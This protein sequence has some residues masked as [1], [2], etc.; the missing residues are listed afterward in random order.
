MV[1]MK[2]RRIDILGFKSFR[3]RARIELSDGMTAI[4][5]PNGCGKSN[6]V[7]AIKWA[8]GDMSPKSL[9]GDSMRDVIFAGSQDYKPMGFAEVTLT[10]ENDGDFEYADAEW[11]DIPREF[12]EVAEISV[13]RRLHR[14]GDSEYLINKVPCRLMDIQDLLAG[15]GVGK[16]GYSIIEQNRV[17][18]IVSA[19][20][21]ERRLLIEEASGITRY[22]TQRDRAERKLTKAE[23]NLTRV[24]DILGEIT[25]QI[26]SLERQ[27]KKA[28]R[29]REY[30]TELE[31][32]EVKVL[33]D[34]RD[35]WDSRRASGS[36][37]LDDLEKALEDARKSV[38]VFEDDL[39]SAKVAA[40]AAEKKHAEITEA[41]YRLDTRLNLAKNRREH[42]TASIEEAKKRQARAEQDV[43]TQLN[44]K[45]LLED[46]L[47]KVAEELD[48][49][50][51]TDGEAAKLA[52]DEERLRRLRDELRDA[53]SAR[54][55]AREAFDDARSQLRWS[56][57]RLAL[58]KEQRTSLD[59][60]EQDLRD[61]IE[62]ASEQVGDLAD[63]TDELEQEKGALVDREA[64]LSRELVERR[65]RA[66]EAHE[67]AEAIERE[68]R[69]VS[70]RRIDL[71]NRVESLEAMRSAGAGYSEI[72]PDIVAWARQTGSSGV[73]GPLGD[74]IDVAE[75]RESDV[76]L[77]LS[78]RVGDILVA[79]RETAFAAYDAVGDGRPVT[80]RVVEDPN[81]AVSAWVESIRAVDGVPDDVA[82]GDIVVTPSLVVFGDG[83]VVGG[84]SS[85]QA[86]TLLRQ[87]RLL[88]EYRAELEDA[89]A[90]ERELDESLQAAMQAARD[91][92]ERVDENRRALD[93]VRLDLRAKER[94]IASEAREIERAKGSVARL[95]AQ[96]VPI[97]GKQEQLDREANELD[98]KRAELESK[99]AGFE[100]AAAAA[101][102]GLAELRETTEIL[103]ERVTSEKVR[104]AQARERRRNLV[105]SRERLTRSISSTTKLIANYGQE[106]EE[107]AIRTEELQQEVERHAD[108]VSNANAEREEAR[109]GVEAS[110]VE[111][112]AANQSVEEI[113]L[114]MRKRRERVEALIE[115]KQK[116]ELGANEAKMRVAGI[117]EQ[118]SERFGLHPGAAAKIARGVE[119]EADAAMARRDELRDKVDKLGPVNP[120]AEEEYDEAVE[121][122]RFLLEQQADLQSS[123]ADLK[124]AIA[125]MDRE[126]R[127]RFKETFDAVNAKFMEVFPRL[128][129]G[130]RAELILTE[131]DDLLSTGVDIQ[132]QPPGKRLQSVSLLSGGEKALTATSLIFSIFLLK[133]TPFSILDEV[134]A[135][136]DEANV[137]RFALMVKEMSKSSQMIVITHSRRSMESAEMLYGV[138]MEE[139]GVSKIVSVRLSEVS[140]RLAS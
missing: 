130:G 75:Q 82:A 104:L 40:F 21:S 67:R 93:Q 71:E 46:E 105:E 133:P 103:S 138:T 132:V 3:D 110:R 32:L 45:A 129:R 102:A 99:L 92:D 58:I 81:A 127:R 135:P 41:F 66:A 137:G 128:F 6:V 39:N 29:Y 59:A 113:E 109:E 95:E 100:D 48:T 77:G 91:L 88:E 17:G 22:K 20:P 78:D 63:R 10:F 72:V 27:A 12:R 73:F 61:E 64:L 7:D 136:L 23:D 131:P 108:D 44:R 140:D 134:D 25:K 60:R 106:A 13:T 117:D 98:A 89:R 121:R 107:Q 53:E 65:E 79:S 1:G 90:Q 16:Q 11:G 50:G 43:K 4:V 120:M 119:L 47:R 86:A 57:D 19:K 35:E 69:G 84:Q 56:N 70:A 14:N 124:Q 36:E 37:G 80:F 54:E 62:I 38:Q 24:N 139:P 26:R 15:T 74:F 33:V 101:E 30:A 8:M 28:A 118:L 18:F 42:A 9:R 34:K 83:R 55:K 52:K 87:R 97:F 49:L 51:S 68:L 5:G 126:S 2:L 116:V 94:E 115:E 123:V 31:A 122:N 112:I 85:D 96:L 114:K 111:L 125:R 76:A